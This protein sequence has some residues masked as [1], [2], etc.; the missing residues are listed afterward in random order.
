MVE[1]SAALGA[2]NRQKPMLTPSEK[3]L[4]ANF[5]AGTPVS[6]LPSANE[7]NISRTPIREALRQL[8]TEGP[9]EELPPYG[10]LIRFESQTVKP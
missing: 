9:L 2:R 5:G 8:I 7:L 4:P 1:L 10:G 3:S 6:E